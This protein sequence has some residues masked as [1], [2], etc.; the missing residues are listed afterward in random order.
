MYVCM[1][2]CVCVCMCVYVTCV[3]RQRCNIFRTLFESDPYGRKTQ[4]YKNILSGLDYMIYLFISK[5][6]GA[7][8]SERSNGL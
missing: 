5:K 8:V 3:C 1:Y 4:Q 7:V 6:G 2:V